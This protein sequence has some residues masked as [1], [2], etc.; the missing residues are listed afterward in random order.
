[1]EALPFFNPRKPFKQACYRYIINGEVLLMNKKAQSALEYLLTYGWAILIVII[2]GASLYALGVFNPGTFTGK[3]VTGFTQ[4]QMVDHK[5]DTKVNMTVM[6]GNRVGKTV[7]LGN[8][9]GTYKNHACS[10]STLSGTT[11]GAN[12]QFNIT[13]KCGGSGAGTWDATSLSF[14]SS[15][16]I[17][18]DLEYTD[19][20][21]GIAHV[22][23]G[24]LFGAV[25][26]T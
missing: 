13:L 24:T 12:D 2:V 23:S 6:F 10:S 11:M 21:S 16:S 1:L 7:T 26:Q 14:R 20:D 8:I 5:V 18:V 19:T 22:D 17:I 9:T 25:E 3:R 4:F 15:Y